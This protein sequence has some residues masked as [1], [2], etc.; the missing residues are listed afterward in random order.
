MR[1]FIAVVTLLS[2]VKHMLL[3]RPGRLG[4]SQQLARL[5]FICLPTFHAWLTKYETPTFS[6]SRKVK[7]SSF[8]TPTFFLF[9]PPVL[10][11]HP[12]HSLHRERE[13]SE[14]GLRRRGSQ[15]LSVRQ[16]GQP[17]QP[18]RRRWVMSP[19]IISLP[20]SPS[21]AASVASRGIFWVILSQ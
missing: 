21:H 3:W 12:Y 7:P 2:A 15:Q 14:V 18:K 5:M 11:L 13:T 17:G 4:F 19:F 10:S 1:P 8:N 20:P 6:A 9:F 16:L